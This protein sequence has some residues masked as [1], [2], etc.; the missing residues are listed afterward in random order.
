MLLHRYPGGPFDPLGLASGSP[1]SVMDYKEKELKNGRVAMLAF[2][3]FAGQY[4]ATGKGPIDNL[5]DHVN[6]PWGTVF[7]EYSHT[8]S[9]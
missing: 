2:A 1:A 6:N 7:G 4:A 8:Q 9:V 3:G 5:I